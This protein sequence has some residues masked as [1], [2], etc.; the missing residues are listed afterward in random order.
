M[1]KQIQIEISEDTTQKVLIPKGFLSKTKLTKI[2]FGSLSQEVVIDRHE[3]HSLMLSKDIAEQLKFPNFSIPLHLFVNNDTLYIG[4]LVGIFTSG[5]TP[6]QM[7]PIGE[8]SLFFSKLLSVKKSVGALPFVFGEQHIDWERGVIN[9]LFYHHDGWETYEVPFPN[10]IYD[11]LPNRKSERQKQLKLVKERLQT[12]YMIPWYNPGFFNKLDINE[13]L[14]QNEEIAHYLPETYEFSSFSEIEK[15]LA[16]YGHVFIKPMNG[17]SGLGIHQI[18]YDRFEGDYYCRF[19]N[20]TGDNKLLK[21]PSLESLMSHIFAERKLNKMLVQ[22][23][24]HLIRSDKR[25]IDFRVHTNKDENGEWIVTAIAAKLAGPGSVTTHVNNGGVI[26]T[27]AELFPI[28]EEQK[29]MEEKLTTAALKI[30]QALEANME[31][32]IGEIGF[33]LGL[34]R[35]GN[36]WLFEANSKPGRSIF[37]N[38]QLKDFDF[39]TRKLSLAFSVYLTEKVITRPEEMFK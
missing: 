5:F 15:M 23:G 27:L 19:R 26:K 28:P 4:P 34:D 37:K 1:K 16:D 9:G 10:V 38:P 33:D 22:Q 11:R 32:I 25:P 14:L 29:E 36:V 30:S 12:E 39:L 24:I 13:R 2:S 35:L 21:F 18:L 6:F 3:R 8:R 31:G 17:S 7:R 20:Q